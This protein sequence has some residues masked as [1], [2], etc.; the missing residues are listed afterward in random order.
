MKIVITIQNRGHKKFITTIVGLDKFGVKL[1][2]AAKK[3]KKK[4]AS[5]C[6]VSDGGLLM[7]GDFSETMEPFILKEFKQVKADDISVKIK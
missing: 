2:E 4:F 3:M 1:E 7:Q 5:G 6:S